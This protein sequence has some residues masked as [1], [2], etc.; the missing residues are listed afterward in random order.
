MTKLIVRKISAAGTLKVMKV[1][2]TL[3]VNY[4]DIK[5]ETLRNAATRLNSAGRKYVVSTDGL[6]N[7]T[8]V[9]RIK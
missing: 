6:I 1:G 4:K 5:T 2:E 7:K 8:R 3:V 9:S